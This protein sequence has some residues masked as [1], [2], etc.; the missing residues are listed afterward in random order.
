MATT[1]PKT[2]APA[3]VDTTAE[4]LVT[5]A[6]IDTA[7]EA[8]PAPATDAPQEPTAAPVAEAAPTPVSDAETQAALA[9]LLAPTATTS[10]PSAFGEIKLAV[11]V[12]NDVRLP[13]VALAEYGGP[14]AVAQLLHVLEYARDMAPG[15]YIDEMVGARQQQ[16]LWNQ[17][18]LMLETQD[19]RWRQRFAALLNFVHENRQAGGAF[20]DAH[21]L[22]FMH[23][24]VMSHSDSKGFHDVI[25]I[26]T[27]LADPTTRQ[28]NK[29]DIAWKRV[30][31][32]GVS[33]SARDRVLEFFQVEG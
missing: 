22:R 11:P 13:L 28:M 32:A 25:N 19:E 31:L 10:I 9:A 18:K 1:R 16:A 4:T 23:Q 24:V 17:L 20:T 8:A 29:R 15:L 5:T 27:H 6:P 14:G 7:A 2:A 21:V 33:S 3:V 30:L 12:G 26:I